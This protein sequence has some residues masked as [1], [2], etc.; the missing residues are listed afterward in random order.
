MRDTSFLFWD[1]GPPWEASF[2]HLFS[3]RTPDFVS[4]QTGWL[5]VSWLR[6]PTCVDKKSISAGERR[7]RLNTWHSWNSTDSQYK[8][9]LFF[10]FFFA[11]SLLLVGIS[12]RKARLSLHRWVEKILHFWQQKSKY[13]LS[14]TMEVT[15]WSRAKDP[16]PRPKVLYILRYW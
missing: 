13:P 7:H 4:R 12:M 2:L 8:I 15:T 5:A 9:V 11:F 3:L 10:F 14:K 1:R 6:R 16:P